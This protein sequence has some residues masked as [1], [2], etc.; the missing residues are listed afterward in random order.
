MDSTTRMHLDGLRSGNRE[1]ENAAFSYLMAATEAPIDPEYELWEAM[2][3][4]LGSRSNRQRAIAAQTLCRLAGNDPEQRMLEDFDSLLS[5]TKD[6]RFVTARHCLQ[7]LWRVGA[8]G[9]KQRTMLLDGLER[10][11]RECGTEKNCTLIRYDIIESLRKVYDPTGDESVR[12]K[13]LELVQAEED[14][15]YRKKYAALWKAARSPGAGG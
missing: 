9:E 12:E 7:S 2:V 13:A 6:E 1:L 4:M 11:F 14:L 5:V 3:E 10:R 8:A 15:K